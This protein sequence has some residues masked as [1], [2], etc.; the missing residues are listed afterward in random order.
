MAEEIQNPMRLTHFD[1]E[2]LMLFL[3]G[4]LLPAEDELLRL[5]LPVCT[6]CAEKLTDLRAASLALRQFQHV[7]AELLPAPPRNW[8]GFENQI[9]L[10]LLQPAVKKLSLGSRFCSEVRRFFSSPLL[11]WALSGAVAALAMVFF[12][13]HL[14]LKHNLTVN[15]VLSRSEQESASS[16]SRASTVVFQK[17]RITDSAAPQHPVTVQLWSD[18]RLGRYREVMVSSPAAGTDRGS[19]KPQA[20]PAQSGQEQ[21]LSDLHGVFDAN[22]LPRNAAVSASAFRS[23][24]QAGGRKEESIREDRLANGE[25]VYRLSAQA[26]S[27]A[28]TAAGDSP[29]LRT[30]ELLVRASDFHAVEERLTLSSRAGER[31]FEIAELEYRFASPSELPE[32]LF[33]A[34]GN[35]LASISDVG[36]PM[37]PYEKPSQIDLAV[38]AL[39]RLDRADAL[40]QDQIVVTRAAA[41]GVE[42]HGFVRN[43]ARKSEILAVLGA[44]AS[45]PAVKLNLLSA[46]SAQPT[47]ALSLTHLM[48]VQSIEVQLSQAG[49]VSEV[50]NYLA[51]HRTVPEHD[52]EQAADRFVT[53][54]VEHSTAAQLNA[55]ALKN[56]LEIGPSPMASYVSAETRA[57]WR[58][59]VMRHSQMSLREIQL[60]EQQLAPIF[61]PKISAEGVP[62]AQT[63]GPDGLQTAADRLLSQTTESDRILW[64]AFSSNG[65]AADRNGLTD[66]RFWIMLKEECALAKQ[67][68]EGVRP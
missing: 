32:G 51:A 31:T 33:G 56:I 43:E 15:D 64:Q 19:R 5:H 65:D 29:F 50:R 23:W 37:L 6:E 53:D 3:D 40:V 24:T 10:A 61:S 12:L 7:S 60:L 44:L 2:K 39:G 4:E 17:I 45:D 46:T 18:H 25:K 66:A 54:A 47:G 21:L 59:L 63:A 41:G 1:E 36:K 8:A 16:A 28:S 52:L 55:Q 49:N 9:R 22:Q 30:M 27:P 11:P 14:S 20:N 48:Q 68:T 13:G 34:T 67:L 35:G 26:S 38:E 62:P 42:I 58:A 57:R